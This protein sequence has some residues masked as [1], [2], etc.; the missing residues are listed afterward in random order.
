MD[1]DTVRQ[2]LNDDSEQRIL[3]MAG[4]TPER[5]LLA[6]IVDVLTE[7]HATLIQ[8]NSE[9]G[10]RPPVQHLP[11]PWTVI[12]KVETKKAVAEHRERVKLFL[13]SSRDT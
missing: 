9:K 10:K 2:S 12:E 1:E 4:W 6:T 7:L 5:E 11:R 8:A 3:S 13:A